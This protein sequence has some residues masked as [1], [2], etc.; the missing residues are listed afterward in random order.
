MVAFEER[1]TCALET[2]GPTGGASGAFKGHQARSPDR[3]AADRKEGARLLSTASVCIVKCCYLHLLFI[4]FRS[5]ASERSLRLPTSHSLVA[6]AR[7]LA[8]SSSPALGPHPAGRLPFEGARGPHSEVERARGRAEPYLASGNIRVPVRARG[9]QQA[10]HETE[11]VP[12]CLG[13]QGACARRLA[14]PT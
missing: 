13:A 4:T 1:P 10:E 12:I 11:V 3:V 14:Q 8:F 2:T 7:S 6:P 5:F 9:A